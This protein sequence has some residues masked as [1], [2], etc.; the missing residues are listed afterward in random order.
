VRHLAIS[1]AYFNIPTL[2]L[3][4]QHIQ[5]LPD[6][7]E[8][9]YVVYFRIFGRLYDDPYHCVSHL[10]QPHCSFLVRSEKSCYVAPVASC[11]KLWWAPRP[12]EY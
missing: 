5:W 2:V 11:V 4:K 10:G 6:V 8:F 1:A 7:V 9:Q 3:Q 12:D